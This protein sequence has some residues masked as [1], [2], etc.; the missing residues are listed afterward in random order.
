MKHILLIVLLIAL[1][2]PPG[3]AQAGA[4]GGGVF[5]KIPFLENSRSFPTNLSPWS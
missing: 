4:K 5:W 1:I 3:S 2:I